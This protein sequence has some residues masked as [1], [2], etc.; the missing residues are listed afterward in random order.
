MKYFILCL[1]S[2]VSLLMT[3]V[4]KCADCSTPADC[5]IKALALLNQDRDEMRRERDTLIKKIQDL[6]NQLLNKFNEK[7]SDMDNKINT[8]SNIL[9]AKA[10]R[11]E[12]NQLND[13]KSDR[14]E[15]SN[16][17]N[18]LGNIESRSVLDGDSFTIR[19][20]SG[21][22][23]SETFGKPAYIY[24]H[25]GVEERVYMEKCYNGQCN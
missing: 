17:N 5:Y 6:E 25:R 1:V 23:L 10:D 21:N 12:I 9:S 7:T 20:N 16:I 22:R 11:S 24:N 14:S 2:L 3:S 15:V 13:Q 4:I 18:R 8:I 19:G